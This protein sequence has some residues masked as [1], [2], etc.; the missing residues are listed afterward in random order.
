MHVDSSSNP[1]RQDA[2]RHP[3]L[4]SNPWF[5]QLPCPLQRG[6]GVALFRCLYFT[7]LPLCRCTAYSM[8]RAEK[9]FAF[10]P[11]RP[12][13]RSPRYNARKLARRTWQTFFFFTSIM[14]TRPASYHP[15]QVPP[16]LTLAFK[17]HQPACMSVKL[18][19]LHRMTPPPAS[20]TEG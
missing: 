10:V 11:P 7:A 4:L 13:L 19:K 12:T 2:W 14:S 1:F 15:P 8:Y 6:S 16:D 20:L 18:C 3:I 9:H 5:N 17:P